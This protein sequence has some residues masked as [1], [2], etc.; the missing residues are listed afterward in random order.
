M[1]RART[2]DQAR[3]LRR[4]AQIQ[5]QLDEQVKL[6]QMQEA[7]RHAGMHTVVYDP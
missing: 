6:D 1:S 2:G 5:T 3:Q 4:V 7:A